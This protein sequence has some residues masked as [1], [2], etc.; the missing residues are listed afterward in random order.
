MIRFVLSLIMANLMSAV[1]SVPGHVYQLLIKPEQEQQQQQRQQHQQQQ[2]EQQKQQQE[3]GDDGVQELADSV[4]SGGIGA[5]TWLERLVVDDPGH[6]WFGSWYWHKQ[7]LDGLT[8][9]VSLASVLSILLISLDRYYV[10]WFYPL[11]LDLKIHV[12]QRACYWWI[13]SGSRTN[14][15]DE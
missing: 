1:V 7:G 11:A 13:P 2:Q 12:S 3:H 4:N 14:V 10:S 5:V 8:V 9:L 6:S 15:K